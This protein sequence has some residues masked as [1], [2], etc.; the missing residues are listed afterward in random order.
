[1]KTEDKLAPTLVAWILFD[2]TT[3]KKYIK[4]NPADGSLAI[5]DTE[6]AAI[7]AKKLHY[8]TDYKRCEYYSAPQQPPVAWVTEDTVDGQEVSGKPRRVWWENNEGVG[9]PIYTSQPVAQVG[10]CEDTALSL[11]ERT[12]STEVDEQLAEDIIQYARRLHSRYTAPQP[13]A[14]VVPEITATFECESIGITGTTAAPIKRIEL[15]DCGA[16]EVILDY[17]PSTSPQTAFLVGCEGA[18]TP[19]EKPKSDVADL[20][21]ALEE[22]IDVA[23]RVDGWESF[24]SEPIERAEEAIQAY[25]K[26]GGD[27]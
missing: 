9:M 13:S 14:V 17:W 5:F 19:C 21:E 8:G 4:M 26:Q 18:P 15:H 25:R 22:M 11:A 20:V 12:F 2:T 3:D 1:M 7:A 24:P 16:I 27:L 10:F 23:Q 6:E